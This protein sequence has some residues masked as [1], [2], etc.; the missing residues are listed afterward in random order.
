MDH[1][2]RV[3]P[4][5]RFVT[6]TTHYVDFAA[7]Y[8]CGLDQFLREPF[9]AFALAEPKLASRWPTLRGA[10]RLPWRV[11]RF[12]A[13]LAWQRAFEQAHHQ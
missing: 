13:Q 10:S 2:R 9:V 7:A 12:A 6:S 1:W 3:H 8:R 5:Q 11:A 4:L